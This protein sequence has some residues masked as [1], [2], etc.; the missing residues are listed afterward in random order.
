MLAGRSTFTGK[1][2]TDL[3]AAVIRSEPEWGSLPAN[4]HW[5]LREVLERCLKK[6]A[7]D[8]Y[9]DISDLKADI[10]PGIPKPLFYGKNVA[11]YPADGTPWDISP[12]GNRFIMIKPPASPGD[13]STEQPRK[14][15]IVLNW[16]EE[17]KQR[18]PVK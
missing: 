6:D 7:R 5:R 8:R 4:L 15:N 10:S 12:D 18:V 3:L 11:A 17:L 13:P 9:H 1:D 16:T 2:V 14:L